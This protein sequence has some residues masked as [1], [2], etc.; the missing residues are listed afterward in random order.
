MLLHEYVE[1]EAIADYLERFETFCEL[2][3]ITDELATTKY[4]LVCGGTT[5]YDKI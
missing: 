2:N 3:E 5:L 4:L 1:N